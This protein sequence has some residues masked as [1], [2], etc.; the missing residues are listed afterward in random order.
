MRGQA[1][2]G[3]GRFDEAQA[4]MKGAAQRYEEMGDAKSASAIRDRLVSIEMKEEPGEPE[5]AD[6][7]LVGAHEAETPRSA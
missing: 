3:L 7:E 1:F 2:W 4:A 6:L 5:P